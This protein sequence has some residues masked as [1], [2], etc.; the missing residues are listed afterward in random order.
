M[1]LALALCPSV[2]LA[3]SDYSDKGFGLRLPPAFIRFREVS[4]VGGPTVANRY[5]SAV[6]PA[7]A[8][9]SEVPSRFGL[10]LA[11]YF[12]SVMFEEGTRIDVISET[13]NWDSRDWGTFQPTLAQIRSNRDENR[14]GQLFDY[15]VDVFQIQWA[16]RRENFAFGV[17]F[18]Y[19]E[20]ELVLKMSGGPFDG[21][22]LS[23]SHAESYRLRFGALYEPYEKWLTGMV[24]EYG[25]A[26]FRATKKLPTQFGVMTSKDRGVPHQFVFR[27]GVS[28]EYADFSTAYLDHQLGVFLEGDKELKTN[29]F[30]LGFDHRLLDG[31]FVRANGSMDAR[32]NAGW[33]VGLTAFVSKQC[34]FSVGYGYNMYP[35]LRPEFGRAQTL[36]FVL[37][38]CF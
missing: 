33:Q 30:F 38:F 26:P 22:R 25:F 13:V 9:W 17:N 4:A 35:E 12:S 34:S 27:S 7:S 11:P 28:Y 23:E 20:A 31:L 24:F 18:N 29:R 2:S 8:D 3:G 32:G 14:Q 5:S 19:S 16:K 37:S 21:L 6:N 15:S 36:Q 10:V 1:L